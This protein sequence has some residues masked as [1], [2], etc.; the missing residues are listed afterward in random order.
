MDLDLLIPIELAVFLGLPLLLALVELFLLSRDS[1][2]RRSGRS[3]E[4]PAGSVREASG[5]GDPGHAEGQQGADPARSKTL[6]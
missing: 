4:E 6:E 3:D 2:T 1:A 5:P